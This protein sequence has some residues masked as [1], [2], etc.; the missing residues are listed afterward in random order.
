MIHHFEFPIPMSPF[1]STIS[2]ILSS[3]SGLLVLGRGHTYTRMSIS[4]HIQS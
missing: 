2:I 3:I 4:K 1:L